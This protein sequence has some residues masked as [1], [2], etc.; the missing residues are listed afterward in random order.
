[1]TWGSYAQ[2]KIPLRY[3]RLDTAL[4]DKRKKGRGYID[5]LLVGNNVEVYRKDD[6]TIVLKLHNTEI[7]TLYSN[8]H[9]RIHVNGWHTPTTYN[10][11]WQAVPVNFRRVKP[12]KWTDAIIFYMSPDGRHTQYYDGMLVNKDNAHIGTPPLLTK[13]I[14][15]EEAKALRTQL[16]RAYKERYL[17]HLNMMS[18]KGEERIRG[19]WVSGS[20]PTLTDLLKE[21]DEYRLTHAAI[22]CAAGYWEPWSLAHKIFMKYLDKVYEEAVHHQQLFDVVPYEYNPKGR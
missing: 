8:G 2:S 15:N 12:N 13:V 11:V 6:D 16:L 19:A 9:K 14:P 10:W 1:M 4:H 22:E 5:K 3:A 17:P 7:V 18:A 20:M 21:G